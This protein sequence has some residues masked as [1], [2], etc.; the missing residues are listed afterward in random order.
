MS[1]VDEA[2]EIANAFERAAEG[3]QTVSA[4]YAVGM[5]L[6]HLESLAGNPDRAGLFKIISGAMDDWLAQNKKS[7]PR[8]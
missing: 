4:I 2:P 8:A 3:K 6:G 5:I 7:A 1:Y